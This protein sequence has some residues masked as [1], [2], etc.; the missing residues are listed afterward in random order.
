MKTQFCE[1]KIS[2]VVTMSNFHLSIGLCSLWLLGSATVVYPAEIFTKQDTDVT[3]L[4]SRFIVDASSSQSLS[5][6]DAGTENTPCKLFI[7][8]RTLKCLEVPLKM[9]YIAQVDNSDNLSLARNNYKRRNYKAAFKAYF[10]LAQQGNLEA[11]QRLGSIYEFGLGLPKD[12]KKADYWYRKA[13]ADSGSQVLNPSSMSSLGYLYS[14]GKGVQ[15]DYRQ[16][17][18]WYQKAANQ[19]DPYA[20]ARLGNMYENGLG[21]AKDYRQAEAWYRKAA[22]QG[23]V[24]AKNRLEYMYKN[25]LGAIKDKGKH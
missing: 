17:E 13:V 20:Q 16:A 21:V 3:E 23:N 19:G 22:D 12:L 24:I 5:A 6:K 25:G 15:K 1:H 9:Q 14:N 4:I 2:Q 11:Q 18:A 10:P 7:M 8:P